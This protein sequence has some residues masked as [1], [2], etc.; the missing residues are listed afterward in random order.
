ML[1]KVAL[2]NG[3]YRLLKCE[4]NV[5]SPIGYRVLFRTKDGKGLTGIVVG[6]GEGKP[7]G[8]V[9]S[10]PDK[11]PLV[12]PHSI[13]LVKDLAHHYLEPLGRILW[14]FIPS[15]FDWYEE[16]VIYLAP[17][18]FKGL[19]RESLEIVEYLKKK[20]KVKYELLKK[21]FSPNHLRLLL[22]HKIL[23]RK[24]EWIIPKIEEEVFKLNLSLEEA[25]NKVRSEE[26][27]E[28]ILYLYENPFATKGELIRKGFK[29]SHIND[30]V[31]RGILKKDKE[32]GIHTKN[33]SIS[34]ERKI[35]VRKKGNEIISGSFE[36]VVERILKIVERNVAI[37]KNTLILVPNRDE[38]IDLISRLSSK[39]GY[40]VIEIS[41]RISPKKLYENW[42]KAYEKGYV[43]LGSFKAIL[44]PVTALES[45]IFFNELSN[46]RFPINN[47]DLRR[48]AYIL[49]KKTGA[50]LIFA[51][52]YY[53]LES[54]YL[55]GKKL[56]KKEEEKFRANVHVVERKNEIIT[57][58]TFNFLKSIEGDDVLFVVLK[59]GY[60][61]LYCPR[62]ES[63]VEC[64]EC[65]TFLTY[66]K[67]KEL[68]FC[69][70]KKSHYKTQ[71]KL[72][73]SCGNRLE[74]MGFGI[75]RAKETIERLFG[76]RDNFSFT[77]FPSW[78]DSWEH[79]IILNADSVLSVPSYKS[80]EKFISLIALALRVAKKTL[81]IQTGLLSE[82]EKEI[83]RRKNLETLYEK[84]LKDR[85]RNNLPP[86]S[87]LI[88]IESKY[89]ISKI[90]KEKVNE[91]F[92][93]I[94][95]DKRNLWI[96]MLSTKDSNGILKKLRELKRKEK[97]KIILDWK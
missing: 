60:S 74:E 20:K 36:F 86:F 69:S 96:Y 9:I 90:L 81:L 13:E 59:Q 47:I 23:I 79:V 25:L 27:K 73:P 54:F 49:S 3:Q 89:D 4:E 50:E 62:C 12:L 55:V 41:S 68:I 71:E 28:L 39:L 18:S 11:L 78:K 42:F 65:G 63:I 82:E 92:G 37:G 40:R 70:N 44:L 30:L 5:Q 84:E 75:E 46:T 77:T 66:S 15:I 7:Q 38:L 91:N 10:F 83:L 64:P 14:D 57:E 93:M 24:K 1:I 19:D 29:I 76:K 21:R 51:T 58:E 67:E 94:Y 97:M 45:I 80:K 88:F 87:K 17:R 61:Y 95:D 53:T 43:F 31:K 2:A 16:E 34:P 22:E 8:K 72:C 32:Y 85:E 6:S 52:P 48:V 33:F 26:K 35:L 56:F